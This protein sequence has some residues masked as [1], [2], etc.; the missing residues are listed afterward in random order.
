MRRLALAVVASTL[1]LVPA[2]AEGANEA[3]PG[4]NGPIVFASDRT[5][6]REPEIY[7]AALDGGAPRNLT[8]DEGWDSRPVP[9]PDGRR[10]AFHAASGGSSRRGIHVMNVD[11]SDRR[12]VVDAG[13]RPSWAPDSRRLAYED[14]LGRIAVIDMET[15][16]VRTLVEGNL[17]SWSPD[18][19]HIGFL[20]RFQ[21]FVIDAGGGEPRRVAAGLAV[22]GVAAFEPAWSPDG[23]QIVFAGGEEDGDGFAR[24][25]DIHVVRVSDRVAT[26]LA[27]SRNEKS[28]PAWSPDGTEIVYSERAGDEPRSEL[29]VITPAGSGRRGLTGPLP[30]QFDERPVWSPDSASVAFVR[31]RAPTLV[32]DVFIVRRDGTGLRRVTQPRSSVPAYEAPSWLPDGRTILFARLSDDLDDDLFVTLPGSEGVRRLTDNTVADRDPSWSPDGALIAFVRTLESGPFGRRDQNHELFVM[33]ADGSGVRRLT[34]YRDEDLAPAWAPDG[35]RIAFVRRVERSGVVAIYTIRPDGTGLRRMTV[36]PPGFH[37]AP[38]WSPDGR[39]IAFTVDQ[40]TEQIPLYLVNA[41]GTHLRR[42]ARIA[43]M[44]QGPQWSPDGR[45]IAVTGLTGCGGPCVIPAVYVVRPDGTGL[46]KLAENTGGSLA[47]SPDGRSLAIAAGP[48]IEFDLHTGDTREIVRGDANHD[49]PDWQPRCTRTGT[50]RA[51]RLAGS[52][53]PDLLCAFGGSDRLRGGRGSDRLFGGDGDDRIDAR[54]GTFDVVGCGPGRDLVLADK[55]D[56]VGED[57][58][59]RQ[60]LANNLRRPT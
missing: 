23:T 22:S 33:R 28:G 13:E 7:A 45:L 21:I 47:W 53:G 1:A 11:G 31:G 41:D 15:R 58:E 43:D 50:A 36:R 30:L 5:S 56:L 60:R 55:R 46:R 18:G 9:S 34:R 16:A 6:P 8:G 2:A 27:A 32:Q 24:S 35:S 57:C 51:D 37:S 40:G 48:I 17:P 39:S 52:S 10:I 49:S 12:P 44:A 29:V 19:R 4:R 54:D 26:R 25:S 59:R 42:V 38:A 3:F 14:G 20:R